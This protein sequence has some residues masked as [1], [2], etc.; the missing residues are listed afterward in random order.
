MADEFLLWLW[1]G[2]TSDLIQQGV[3]TNELHRVIQAR[4]VQ[5]IGNQLVEAAEAGE[6]TRTSK[7]YVSNQAK[8]GH[9]A[10]FLTSPKRI[11]FEKSDLDTWM[12]S[13]RRVEAT[14][15]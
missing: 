10:Y 14:G 7:D 4:S 1:Q 8:L 12:N 3:D 15:R 9:I 5:M 6:Y 11:M 13:W 2:I